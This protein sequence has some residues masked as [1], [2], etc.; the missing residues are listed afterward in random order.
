VK[1]W[2]CLPLLLSFWACSPT[3]QPVTV[4]VEH[5]TP[6]TDYVIANAGRL[7]GLEDF[8]A[9]TE[10][11]L[12]DITIRIVPAELPDIGAEGYYR[13]RSPGQPTRMEITAKDANG[14]LYALLDV[15]EQLAFHDGKMELLEREKTV[16]PPLPNRF[17]K[18]NLPWSSY[19]K[20]PALDLHEATCRDTLFWRALY[21][22]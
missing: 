1:Y 4:F 5:P 9:V 8:A 17:I 7:F 6:Q 22:R 12:A 11:A 21:G 18:F 10:S 14:A 19:R 20:S 3:P 15:A 2:F 13:E 16:S